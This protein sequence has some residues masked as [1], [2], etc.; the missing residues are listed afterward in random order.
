MCMC[1]EW[2]I[3]VLTNPF[4]QRK[5]KDVEKINLEK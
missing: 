5:N 4:C 2:C 1:G 3:L